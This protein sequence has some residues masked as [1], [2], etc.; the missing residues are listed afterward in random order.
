LL[1]LATPFIFI[2]LFSISLA[3]FAYDLLT[4]NQSERSDRFVADG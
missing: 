4:G 3:I 1:N 2:S